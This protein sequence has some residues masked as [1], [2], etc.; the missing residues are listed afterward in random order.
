[1]SENTVPETEIVA[2]A[3]II[4]DLGKQKKGRIKSLRKGK[5][6]LLS[7]IND[8]LD[9]LKSNGVLADNAQPVIIVVK[10]KPTGFCW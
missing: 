3:P 7:N 8:C 6:K 2:N 9:E 10:E 1:M 5:G 4:I